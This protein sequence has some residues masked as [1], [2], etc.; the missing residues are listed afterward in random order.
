LPAGA[1]I[2]SAEVAGEKVKPVQGA[3]GNR[4]PLLRP[5]FRPADSYTV[6]Y[7]FLHAGIPFA[8]KGAAELSL[9]RMDVPIGLVEWEV[10]LPGRYK[11]ADFSGQAIAARLLPMTAVEPGDLHGRVTDATGA[12][13]S[14]ATVA[15]VHLPTGAGTTASTDPD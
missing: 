10:F 1:S 8:K 2:L 13:L 3:D 12:A 9:P 4:V 6:S 7:V 5:G 14:N 15:I 11:V